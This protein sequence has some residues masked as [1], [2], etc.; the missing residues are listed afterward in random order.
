MVETN[1]SESPPPDSANEEPSQTDLEDNTCRTVLLED[2]PAESDAFGS[3][4]KVASAIAETIRQEEGG[5]A[6]SLEGS[7]GSGKSTIVGFVK[8]DLEDGSPASK[9]KVFTYDAWAH[10]GDSLRRAFIEKLIGF[11]IGSGW[12]SDEEEDDWKDKV[13]NL[14]G[15]KSEEETVEHPRLTLLGWGLAIS[16]LF[17]PLG[18]GLMSVGSAPAFNP[19]A[20]GAGAILA[21]IPLLVAAI[22]FKHAYSRKERSSSTDEE[23]ESTPFLLTKGK[24]E[25][26]RETIEDPEPTSIEFQNAY[27]DLMSDALGDGDRNLLIVIDNL[28]RIQPD[29]AL[30]IWATIRTFF[31]HSGRRPPWFDRLWILV[32]VAPETPKRIWKSDNEEESDDLV[33][34]HMQKMFQTRFQVPPP[35]LSDWKDFF[36]ESAR[37]VFPDH[38]P[39]EDFFALYRLYRRFNDRGDAPTPRDVKRFLNRVGALHR[40]FGDAVPLVVQGAYVLLEDLET[41]TREAILSESDISEYTTQLLPGEARPKLAQVHFA[42]EENKA[43]ELLLK[44]QIIQGLETGFEDV[45]EITRFPGFEDVCYAVLEDEGETWVNTNPEILL[46]AAASLGNLDAELQPS[47]QLW[48]LLEDYVRRVPGWSAMTDRQSNGAIALLSAL[49]DRKQERLVQDSFL[50][51]PRGAPET[52]EDDEQWTSQNHKGFPPEWAQGIHQILSWVEAHEILA[53]GDTQIPIQLNSDDYVRFIG[54]LGS[55]LETSSLP[56]FPYPGSYEAIRDSMAQHIEGDDLY[57]RLGDLALHLASTRDEID[58]SQLVDQA[59]NR[60]RNNQELSPDTLQELCRIL[61]G[62]CEER[63]SEKAE[64]VLQEVSRRHLFH[65]THKQLESSNVE[66][67]A[68]AGVVTVLWNPQLEHNRVWN[69]AQ[70][71]RRISEIL[72]QPDQHEDFVEKASEFVLDWGLL[73]KVCE[74]HAEYGNVQD[75]TQNLIDLTTKQI[76]DERLLDSFFVTYPSLCDVVGDEEAKK[77][78]ENAASNIEVLASLESVPLDKESIPLFMDALELGLIP[79]ESSLSRDLCNWVEGRSKEE[80]EDDLATGVPI[81]SLVAALAEKG[82]ET[83]LGTAF[84]HAFESHMRNLQQ[85]QEKSP[86]QGVWPD[87]RRQMDDSIRRT[88]LKNLRD[89]V[90]LEASL[91]PTVVLRT[92][93][94][95]IISESVLTE[96]DD[97]ADRAIRS[98]LSRTVSSGDPENLEWVRSLLIDKPE[99]IRMADTSSVRDL[100]EDTENALEATTPED[101][102]ETEGESAH[103]QL[104]AILTQLQDTSESG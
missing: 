9:I 23:T 78:L 21:S 22:G 72:N 12:L 86:L 63:K 10:E 75:F 59:S 18:I 92:F 80:I 20:F 87:I 64:N 16:T 6:I 8:D 40:V 70:G 14:A 89:D 52:D 104:E 15:R 49:D 73:E 77:R 1:D 97:A 26:Y 44:P 24:R 30:D 19:L 76:D 45:E 31:E 69:S 37:A 25:I 5:K 13:E 54:H 94:S 101:S 46:D 55:L 39:E 60:V 29:E 17:I 95:D 56:T 47:S 50:Q 88:L 27:S 38:Q 66:S 28:D 7:W 90:L 74:V 43:R 83:K 84:R 91:D 98:L 71:H 102:S 35:V 62:F 51:Q 34:S 100:I 3:H 41:D 81:L 79:K 48:N 99:L 58:W 33:S 82:M 93:G 68:A 36:Q 103:D 61:V 65:H 53:P 96:S 4:Q 11:I 67:A 32:P 57:P 85:S 42:T 2:L